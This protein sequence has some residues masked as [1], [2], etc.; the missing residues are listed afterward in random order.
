MGIRD[1]PVAP[2]SPWQ[3]GFGERLIGSIRREC[4]DQVARGLSPRECL[5]DLTC[6]PFRGRMWCDVDPDKVSA[7]Q[8]NDDEDIEQVEAHGRG[9]E[10]VHGGDVRRMVTQEGAP[11]RG[12]RSAPLYHK[13]ARAWPRPGAQLRNSLICGFAPHWQNP[14]GSNGNWRSR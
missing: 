4:T 8:S 5:C 2:G 6:D 7:L 10:Q 11:S 12:R 1:K 14:F 3:N 13:D 9:N